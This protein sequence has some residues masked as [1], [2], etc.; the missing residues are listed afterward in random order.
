MLVQIMIKNNND[1]TQ[2][3]SKLNDL[4]YDYPDCVWLQNILTDTGSEGRWHSGCTADASCDWGQ[5]GGSCIREVNDG[6]QGMRQDMLLLGK[7]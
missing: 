3:N 7:L 6:S 5:C 2:I 4:E 1:P